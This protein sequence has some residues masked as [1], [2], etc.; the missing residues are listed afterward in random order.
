MPVYLENCPDYYQ[1]KFTRETFGYVL[2]KLSQPGQQLCVREGGLD[3]I[4]TIYALWE[5]F[6]GM[7]GF[8]NGTDSHKIEAEWLKFLH[9]GMVKGYLQDPELLQTAAK[10]RNLYFRK[11]PQ[12]GTNLEI[13]REALASYCTQNRAHLEP[14]YWNKFFAETINMTLTKKHVFG[15]TYLALAEQVRSEERIK[16]LGKA[17]SRHFAINDPDYNSRLEQCFNRVKQLYSWR[18]SIETARLRLAK[19]AYARHKPQ[20]ALNHL[21]EAKKTI[22]LPPF[23]AYMEFCCFATLEKWNEADTFLQNP[24]SLP[25]ISRKCVLIMLQP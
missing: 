11:L 7:L 2:E 6:I 12:A 10:V 21:T 25:L 16:H 13:F 14:S 22:Q 5:Q 8:E 19:R 23:Y 17:A 3:T 1:K 20:D 9:Y 4:T 15:S 18:P 24:P